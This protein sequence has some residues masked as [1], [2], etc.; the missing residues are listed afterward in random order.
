METRKYKYLSA[1]RIEAL[2]QLVPLNLHEGIIRYIEESIKPGDFLSAVISNDLFESVGRAD[3]ESMSNLEEIVQFFYNYAPSTCW[4]S[5]EVMK[6]WL[7]RRKIN[8]EN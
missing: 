1:D 2:H 8:N 5:K 3:R 6:E 7:E 4:G